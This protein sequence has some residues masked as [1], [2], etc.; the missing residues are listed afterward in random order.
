MIAR[1]ALAAPVILVGM[2]SKVGQKGQVVIPKPWRDRFGIQPGVEVVFVADNDGV[3]VQPARS[4]RDLGGALAGA[5][6]RE[7]LTAER[8]RDRE[9]EDRRRSR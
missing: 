6:L 9:R 5:G 7:E 1:I 2:T 3:R 4:L 8:R